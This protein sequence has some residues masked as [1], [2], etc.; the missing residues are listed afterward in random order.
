MTPLNCPGLVLGRKLC[1]VEVVSRDYEHSSNWRLSSFVWFQVLL[2]I[3]FATLV[4]PENDTPCIQAPL[5]G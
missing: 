4:A 3:G 1:H 5:V 2:G